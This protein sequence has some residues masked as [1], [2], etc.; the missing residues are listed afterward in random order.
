MRSSKDLIDKIW[1]FVR[2][3]IAV[4]E[5]EN[6][7]Y[8]AEKL[9]IL[10]SPDFYLMLISTDYSK[11]DEVFVLK[12]NLKAKLNALMVYDCMC[13]TLSNDDVVEMGNHDPVFESFNKLVKYGKPLWW[14][15]LAQCQSCKQYWMVAGEERINDI[16]ILKRMMASKASEILEDD[17]WPEEFKKYKS[18]L[19][20]GREWGISWTFENPI[21]SALVH[22]TIDLARENPGISTKEISHLLQ[23]GLKQAD[24]LAS[25]AYK[26]DGVKII[27][28]SD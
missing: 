9:E 6:W 8:Q 23:V 18:L 14:L 27:R 21:S 5:F 22:T 28:S 26:K 15:W 11:S 24:A 17:V 7:I 1:R 3:D 19:R 16:F 25:E 4:R 10:F 12:T 2:G 20:I 13:H